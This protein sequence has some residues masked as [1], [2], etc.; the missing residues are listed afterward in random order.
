MRSLLLLSMFAVTV[1]AGPEGLPPGVKNNKQHTKQ[2]PSPEEAVKMFKPDKGFR[3]TLFAGDPHV[4][5]PIS[6]AFDERGRLWVAECFSYP[7]WTTDPK[8]GK[9]RIL[10]FEDTD[11]DGKFDKR[12]VFWDRAY[13]LSSIQ[14]GHGGVWATCAPHLLFIPLKDGEDKPAGEPKVMLDGWSTKIKHNIVNGLTWGPDGWLYGCHGILAESRPG[15]P[16]TPEAKRPRINCGIWRYHPV[17]KQC[18]IVCHGTTNPFGLDFDEHGEGFFTNCVIGHLWNVVPGAHYKRMYGLDYNKYAYELIDA[19]SDHLHWAGGS[20]TDSRGGKGAH[21]DAGGGHAHSG[22]MIY[23]GENFPKEYHNRIFMCNIHGQRLNVD[24]IERKGNSFVGTRAP[25]FLKSDNPWYRGVAV[26][27]GPDGGVYIADWCDLGECHDDDGSH[28]SSGRIYKVMYGKPK[29]TKAFDLRK[30]TDI[31]LAKLLFGNEWFARKA[32]LLLAERHARGGSTAKAQERIDKGLKSEQS[33]A[34]QLRLLWTQY[35]MGNIDER[36]LNNKLFLSGPLSGGEHFQAWAV[37]LL[38]QEGTIS[39]ETLGRLGSYAKVGKS[40]LVRLKIASA[41]QRMANKDRLRIGSL[42][43]AHGEDAGDRVQP[44]LIWYGIEPA[45]AA[46][47]EGGLKLAAECKMPKVRQFVARRLTE[48][49]EAETLDA[50]VSALSRQEETE[51]QADLLRGRRDGLRGRRTVKM[52]AKW[53]DAYVHLSQSKAGTVRELAILL[54]LQFDDAAVL[55]AMR[56]RIADASA[57]SGE[58][59]VALQ[60]LVEK[61]VPGL[62]PT[63]FKLLDDRSMRSPALRALAAY[64]HGDTPKQILRV[65]AKLSDREKQ[66]AIATLASRP[67]YALALLDAVEAKKIPRADV[68]PFTAR[69]LQN[70]KNRA[71][72]ARLNKSWGQLRQSSAEKKALIEKYKNLLTPDVLAK[73]DLSQ[74]RAIFNKTCAQCHMLYGEGHKI[75]PDLTGSDRK[76]LHYVLENSVDPSA[77]IGSDYRLTNITTTKG[78]LVSGIIVEESDRAVTVQTATERIIVPVNEIEERTVASISMMPEGQLEKM[79]QGELRD[80]VGYLQSKQQVPLPK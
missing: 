42:L 31:E 18:E 72:T 11:G 30:K 15:I 26:T 76:N 50:L 27:Y 1:F 49:G 45:V 61:G 78:R 70:L 32:T 19:T 69:Q 33:E 44:L 62:E 41:L 14:I 34:V 66:D 36:Y 80:L 51:V 54:A 53:H 38:C 9:D 60:A 56:S 71:I 68:T 48:T 7:N 2:P 73:A 16:G 79:T 29:P 63:L 13:N 5:Q 59:V 25:D 57:A 20:W 35:L 55:K 74:G 3:V 39:R 58:R 52:P 6:M 43:A 65:Y 67:V 64:K 21:S 40:S 46:D 8:T 47:P 77:V 23:L 28:R 22:C 17:K 24:N 75:G 4:C 12:T 10:I 37:Q